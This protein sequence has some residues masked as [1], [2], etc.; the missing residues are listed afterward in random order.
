MV[1]RFVLSPQR[2]VMSLP[3]VDALNPPAYTEQ[4]L[5]MCSDWGPPARPIQVGTL[6]GVAI[7]AN[8]VVSFPAQSARPAVW[9]SMW[10]ALSHQVYSHYYYGPELFYTNFGNKDN[11]FTTFRLD[12]ALSSFTIRQVGSGGDYE[13]YRTTPRSWTYVVWPTA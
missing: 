8:Y 3:G 2:V 5:A 12:I 11:W 7:A 9:I 13:S 10:A 4:Y 1:A 6:S